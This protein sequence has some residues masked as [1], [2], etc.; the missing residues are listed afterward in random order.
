MF[1]RFDQLHHTQ[2]AHVLL[3]GDLLGLFHRRVLHRLLFRRNLL[4]SRATS[5]F[6]VF[7]S[8]IL[9]LG[10]A[11]YWLKKSSTVCTYILVLGI[12]CNFQIDYQYILT[13]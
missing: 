1:S 6:R 10:D 8:S 12:G 11:Q 9:D 13:D 7:K 2:Q 3:V 5:L 4:L